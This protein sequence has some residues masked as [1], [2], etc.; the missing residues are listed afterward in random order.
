[1]ETTQKKHLTRGQAVIAAHMFFGCAVQYYNIIAMQNN[2]P[3]PK[4]GV[5]KKSEI[6]APCLRVVL[7]GTNKHF[8]AE[9][10]TPKRGAE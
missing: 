5:R 8:L 6:A 3:T 2:Y 9:Y 10:P 7:C 4:K 1:M